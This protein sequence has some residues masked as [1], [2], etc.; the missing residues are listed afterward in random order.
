M[1]VW[2]D[3]CVCEHWDKVVLDTRAT[4]VEVSPCFFVVVFCLRFLYMSFLSGLLL[5]VNV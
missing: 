4:T 1:L 5:F 3:E 2:V